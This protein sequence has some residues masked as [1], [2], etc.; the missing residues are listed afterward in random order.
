MT[1]TDEQRA[2]VQAARDFAGKAMVPHAAEWDA[3][4]L[5][6]VDVL[7]SAGALGF[8]GLYADPAYGGMG[9]SRL[10]SALILEELAR[11]CPSTAAYVSIHNMVAWMLCTWGREEIKKE[12]AA[13][14]A[15]GRKLG[16]Y[17]L[18]EPGF[19]SDAGSLQTRAE[20]TKDGWKITGSKAFISGG[21]DTD[22]L[23]VM[24]RTGAEGPKGISAF[25]VPAKTKGIQY[26]RKEEKLG[27]N[28]QPTRAISFD[29][30]VVPDKNLLGKEGEG[31]K[32]AMKGLNG[33]RVNIAACSLGGGVA[34]F[35]LAKDYMKTRKQFGKALADF[36][37]LQFKLADMATNL[38]ASRRMVHAAAA[39]L[40]AE[41]SEAIPLCAMAKRFAT[42]A[43]FEIV[44]DALQIHGGYGCTKDYPL[45]RIL[46]DLRVHQVVEGTNE[47][48]RVVVARHALEE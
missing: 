22:L 21:G 3:K 2:F 38:E 23:V 45:E 40:D 32:I 30:A 44:N 34:A 47:I 27:W 8:C 19:G 9:L 11:A 10:D 33:G 24:A 18:T 39:A 35:D 15:S 31:F 25:A 48:M 17:C 4:G 29:G 7:R 6:P 28:S 13:D 14:L 5:F 42:D 20:K 36:Q 1:L 26:G 12:W 46:R 16:S 43:C 37:A 41:S